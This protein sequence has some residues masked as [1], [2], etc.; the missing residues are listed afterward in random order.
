MLLVGDPAPRARQGERLR[1]LPSTRGFMSDTGTLSCKMLILV[2]KH[3][4]LEK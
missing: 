2:M 4:L 1:D 3:F